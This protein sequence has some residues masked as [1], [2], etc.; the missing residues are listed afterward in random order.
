[1]RAVFIAQQAR[2]PTLIVGMPGTGKTLLHAALASALG[3]RFVP[4]CG[5]QCTP[6]DVGGLP[7]P[8]P[9]KFLC[10]MMPMAWVEALLTPGGFL[11]LDEF[12][13]V[14][15]GVQAALLTVIQDKRVGDQHLD[16]DTIIAAACNPLEHTPNGTPLTLPTANRFFHAE[17]KTDREAWLDG[18]VDCRWDAPAFPLVPAGFESLVPKWG[19]I[20]QQFLRRTGGELDNVPPVDDQQWA[21]PTERTWR[22]AIYCLAAADAAGGDLFTDN[23]LVRELVAGNVG[24]MAT[25]Q[26]VQ[27]KQ[28]ADLVDPIAILDGTATFEHR[29]DRPDLTL[30]VAAAV[31]STACGPGTFSEDRWD[32]AA[33]FL[34]EI[35]KVAAPE[36]ALKFTGMLRSTAVERKY[37][38]SKKALQPLVDLGVM[39]APRG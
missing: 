23:T 10:R 37:A 38:P 8:D 28:A 19:T 4:V 15:P 12:L 26:F 14:T 39:V 11:F 6:E 34:G 27:W 17:W 5:S 13:T 16:V 9:V 30:T 22:N 29:D 33:A 2:I 1:M 31:A 35:G 21:Y 36:I 32:A 18:L 7:V 3:R 24:E 25:R 20:V